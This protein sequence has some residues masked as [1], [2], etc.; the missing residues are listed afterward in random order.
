[1]VVGGV[2]GVISGL[3]NSI[4]AQKEQKARQNA[5]AELEDIN[6]RYATNRLEHAQASTGDPI[7][8]IL[9]NGFNQVTDAITGEAALDRQLQFTIDLAQKGSAFSK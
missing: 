9:I 1:M 2:L 3:I 6:A 4:A 8:D 7:A 5:I